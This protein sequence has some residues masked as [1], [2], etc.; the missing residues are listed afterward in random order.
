MAPQN[1]LLAA[2][3]REVYARLGQH[4]MTVNLLHG[5]V[6]H[7]PGEAIKHVYFPLDC[8]ISI[9]ITMTDGHTVEAGVVGSREMVGVNAFM[10]GRETNQT[11]Y[12]TQLS[13]SAVRMPAEPLLDEFD[14]CKPL[15]DVM[16]RY[17]QAYIAQLSQ[18]VA[19]NRQH[20]VGQRL[21]RWLLESRDRVPSDDLGLSQE[22]IGQ[23]LG[24]SRPVVSEAAG[25]L[26]AQ[27][28]IRYG[29]KAIK[30]IDSPGLEAASCECYGVIRDEYNRLLGSG[31]DARSA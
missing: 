22:F 17:T 29:R 24:T 19:C 13:G 5:R 3:P 30:I 27:G 18:N 1:L 12:I 4:M 11:E 25:R 7:R 31:R 2:M 6:L 14:H 26:Q 10:G 20:N 23:M 28:L 8:L 9:T 16:L 15:R 21:A